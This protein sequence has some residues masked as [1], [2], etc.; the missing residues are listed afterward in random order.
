MIFCEEYHSLEELLQ[1]QLL[2][3]DGIFLL[4]RK[5]DRLHIELFALYD[6]YVEVFFDLKS[7]DPLY[8]KAFNQYY[9][10]DLYLD[11]INIDDACE[12]IV[13]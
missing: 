10:L 12:R 6:F 1:A 11:Q 8:I 5:T 2:W 3:L 4:S 9:K 7:D 13:R